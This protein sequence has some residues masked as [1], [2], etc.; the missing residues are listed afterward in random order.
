MVVK[1]GLVAIQHYNTNPSSA[2]I[3]ETHYSWIPR[4]N[5]SLCWVKEADVPTVL[6]IKAKICCGKYKPRFFPASQTNVNL[7][8]GIF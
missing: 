4:N 7:W 2:K 3:G 8:E 1:D 5:V 6:S